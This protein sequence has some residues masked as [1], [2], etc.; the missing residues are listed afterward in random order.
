MRLIV[1]KDYLCH[2]PHVHTCLLP[3]KANLVKMEELKERVF[4]REDITNNH[5]C[6]GRGM[7]S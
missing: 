4:F 5:V 7:G 2:V 3:N 1:Y 6:T